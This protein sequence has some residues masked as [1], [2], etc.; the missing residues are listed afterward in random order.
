MVKAFDLSDLGQKL[1]TQAK[2]VAVP[3]TSAVLDWVAESC[4]LTDSAIVK[5]IGGVLVAVKPAVIA[6]VTKAVA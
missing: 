1:L 4:A 2:G 5:G 3:A 6:E